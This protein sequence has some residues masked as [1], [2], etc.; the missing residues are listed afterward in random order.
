METKV[1]GYLRDLC[2]WQHRGSTTENERA[3]AQYVEGALKGFGLPV[4]VETFRNPANLAGQYLIHYAASLAAVAAVLVRMFQVPDPVLDGAVFVFS[5]AASGAAALSFWLETSF[6]ARVLSRLLLCPPSQNVVATLG[7]GPAPQRHVVL[8]AHV[9]TQKSSVM[10]SQWFIRRFFRGFHKRS[11]IQKPRSPMGLPFFGLVVSVVVAFEFGLGGYSPEVFESSWISTLVWVLAFVALVIHIAGC[12]LMLEWGWLNDYVQGANDNGSGVAV[13][14]DVARR[15]SEAGGVEGV[16]FWFV[17]TGCEEAGCGGA[18]D[19]VKRH[20]TELPVGSTD[21]IVVDQVGGGTPRYMTSEGLIERQHA[22]RDILVIIEDLRRA[23]SI[24]EIG[25][26]AS[27]FFTDAGPVLRAG[28]RAVCLSTYPSSLC[29]PTYH[30]QTD[31][32]DNVETETVA[33]MSEV[34]HGV[35]KAVSRTARPEF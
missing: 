8:M 5:L 24:P 4:S 6:R 30:R 18:L 22:S 10:F 35:V 13:M 14:L 16:R 11:S 25:P 3:A 21:F 31:T 12:A 17:A 34:A 26:M 23:G 27:P 32:Y 2:R 15:L 7:P 9:D 33:A 19:F 20:K 1:L 28:Y 29:L